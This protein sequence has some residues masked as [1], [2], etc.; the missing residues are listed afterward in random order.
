MRAQRVWKP[1]GPVKNNAEI[2]RLEIELA[3][4]N[5]RI[6]ELEKRHP[7][8]LTI[9]ALKASALALSRQIDELRCSSATDDL[10][11]LLAK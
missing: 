6:D 9:D 8:G 4:V 11:S 10:T 2:E 7:D 1:V 3:A 5:K